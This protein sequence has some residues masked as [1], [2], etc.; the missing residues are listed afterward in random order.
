MDPS[1]WQTLGEL[2]VV[3]GQ[4]LVQ[5]GALA[6]HWLLLIIWIAWWLLGV[7]WRKAWPALRQGGWAPLVLLTL[8]VALAW[9]RLQP[10]PWVW[11]DT[12]SIP[13][14]WWELLTVSILVGVAL[15]CGWLQGVLGWAPAEINLEPPAHGHGDD[16]AHAANH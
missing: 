1:L 15:F 8:M 5:L 14:F 6:G 12:L 13:A 2:F 7:D 4:L 3:L 10:G 11:Q 16:H 9:S